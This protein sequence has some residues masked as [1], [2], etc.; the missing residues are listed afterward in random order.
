MQYNGI[1]M[2]ERM[3]F[4]TYNKIK[5]VGDFDNKGIFDN[6]ED[7]IVIEEKI[8]GANFRFMIKGDDII[9]GSRTQE[10]TENKEHKYQKNFNR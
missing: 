10:L 1:V 2:G 4:K 6:P 9:F 8:D 5:I 7:E 3:T